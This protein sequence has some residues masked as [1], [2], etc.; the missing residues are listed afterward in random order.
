MI[1]SSVYSLSLKAGIT[2]DTKY[3][4]PEDFHTKYD[5][6]LVLKSQP[7]PNPPLALFNIV[8]IVDTVTII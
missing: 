7:K 2:N 1:I 6:R 5:R 4:K 8:S 3:Y